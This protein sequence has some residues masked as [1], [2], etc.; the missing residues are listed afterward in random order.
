MP[1]CH[2]SRI[3]GFI[4][5]C[6][7]VSPSLTWAS[8]STDSKGALFSEAQ[9]EM[10][11][12]AQSWRWVLLVVKITHRPSR[13]K[14]LL[15]TTEEPHLS[16]SGLCQ[17]GRMGVLHPAF[18]GDHPEVKTFVPQLNLKGLLAS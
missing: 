13:L 14:R 11:R 2:H 3:Q 10:H 8:Q 6:P 16:S 12:V 1:G 9:L 7:P 15:L 17:T 5:T 18:P 4:Q